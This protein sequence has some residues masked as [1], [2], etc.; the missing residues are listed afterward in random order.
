MNRIPDAI[1]SVGYRVNSTEAAHFRKWATTAL[2]DYIIK[3]MINYSSQ[4][5]SPS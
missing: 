1:I 3:P 2:R 4:V 5:P